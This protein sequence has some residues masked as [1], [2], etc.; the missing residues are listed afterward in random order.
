M[1]IKSII[2]AVSSLILSGCSSSIPQGLVPVSGFE[3]D[4]YLGKW[5]EIARLDHSFERGLSNVTAEYSLRDDGD[6]NVVNRGFDAGNGKWKEAHGIAR[7]L[8]GRDTGSLKVSFFRPFWGGYH[9]IALDKKDY[10]SVMIAG[11]DRSY[12]WILS[13]DKSL[14]DAVLKDYVAKAKKWGFDTDKLEYIRQ[15]Q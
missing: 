12:L 4:R 3:A 15:A 11:P 10:K 7:F 13:R 14:D 8:G 1:K 9:I 5:Y 6:I 2:F